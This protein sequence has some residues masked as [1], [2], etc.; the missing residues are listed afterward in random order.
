[1]KKILIIEDEKNIRE[2]I[3]ELLDMFGFEVVS[4]SNGAKGIELAQNTNPQVILCDI[5]MSEMDGYEVYSHIKEIP[6][7]KNIPFAFLTARAEPSDIERGIQM[8]AEYLPKPFTAKEL[9]AK[10]N[11]MLNGFEQNIK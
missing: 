9:I 7:L 3:S 10:V 11:D 6:A 1:M 2:N 8:G 5:S 4:A